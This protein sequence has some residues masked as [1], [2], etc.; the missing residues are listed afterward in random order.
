MKSVAQLVEI[1]KAAEIRKYVGIFVNTSDALRD[2]VAPNVLSVMSGGVE[3]EESWRAYLES[4]YANSS[5]ACASFS[6]GRL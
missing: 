1:D 3:L 4:C 5:N 6:T 2:E